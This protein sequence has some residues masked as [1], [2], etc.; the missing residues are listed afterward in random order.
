MQF[1]LR[2]NDG[3]DLNG[4]PEKTYIG[5]RE[6]HSHNFSGSSAKCRVG[7]VSLCHD[8]LKMLNT[9]VARWLVLRLGPRESI[10]MRSVEHKPLPTALG[11]IPSNGPDCRGHCFADAHNAIALNDRGGA[12]MTPNVRV[13]P[14][15]MR[16]VASWR[17]RSTTRC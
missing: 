15:R 16:G 14:R 4:S 3:C 10:A 1:F 9:D 2:A 11:W 7:I 17:R 8:S 12:C 5:G 13:L 6:R